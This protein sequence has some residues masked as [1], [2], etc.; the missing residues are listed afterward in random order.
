[1]ETEIT[2]SCPSLPPPCSLAEE[3]AGS[4]DEAAQRAAAEAVAARSRAEGLESELAA[5]KAT[6]RGGAGGG[7]FSLPSA[8][9]FISSLG[10]DR[11][12]GERRG[13]AAA[14]DLEAL[15]RVPLLPGGRSGAALQRRVA[16][17]VSLRTL[18]LVGYCA[19]STVACMALASRAVHHHCEDL[20]GL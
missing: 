1:M 20:P 11:K 9:S 15:R 5:A 7:S 3:R 12:G 4:R 13:G 10:L 19:C 8:D 6:S 17:Q 16:G 18:L 2:N 14:M